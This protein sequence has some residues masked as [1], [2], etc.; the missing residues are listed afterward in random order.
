[1]ALVFFAMAA[2]TGPWGVPAAVAPWYH[3]KLVAGGLFFWALS[4]FFTP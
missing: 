2:V 1:V 3:N 4:E